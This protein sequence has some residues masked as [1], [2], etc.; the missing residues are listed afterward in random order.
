MWEL[1][2][3]CWKRSRCRP[4]EA[5]WLNESARLLSEQKRCYREESKMLNIFEFNKF[6]FTT[7]M[8]MLFHSSDVFSLVLRCEKNSQ[9]KQKS[10]DK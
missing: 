7:R 9:N 10:L 6:L 5:G 1:L 8:L 4:H 3:D 2:Q